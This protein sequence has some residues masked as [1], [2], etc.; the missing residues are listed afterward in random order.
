MSTEERFSCGGLPLR[1]ISSGGP[2]LLVISSGGLPLHV[3]SSGGLP[4][5]VL[6]KYES[7]SCVGGSGITQDIV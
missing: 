6:V 3:I 4:L 1:V 5:P 7:K 2:P